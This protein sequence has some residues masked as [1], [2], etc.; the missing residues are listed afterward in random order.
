MR[1][2]YTALAQARQQAVEAVVGPVQRRATQS[3]H[4]IAGSSLGG[5]Q[6]SETFQPSAVRPSNV[7]DGIAIGELS[8]GEQV[9]RLHL[10][11][12]DFWRW[13]MPSFRTSVNWSFSTTF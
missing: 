7:G 9:S 1:L 5:I 2:L 4:R 8:G 10:A 11:V 6:L 13:P 3:L 12:R